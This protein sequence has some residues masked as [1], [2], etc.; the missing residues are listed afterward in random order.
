MKNPEK[1][2]P[3]SARHI[4]VDATKDVIVAGGGIAGVSA[5]LAAARQGVSVALLEKQFGLGGLATLG[6]VVKYLPLC[7]GYGKQVMGGIAEE[8]LHRSVCELREAL[9]SAGFQPVPDCWK[10]DTTPEDRERRRYMATFN[11][12]AFQMQL[13]DVLEEAG[14]ELFYDTR[15]CSVVKNGDD[16]SHVIVENKSGRLALE[17]KAFVDASGDA[18]LCHL[19]GCAVEDFPHNVL[20]SWYYEVKNGQLCLAAFSN[21]YDKEHGANAPGPFYSGTNHRDI[22]RQVLDSRK[23]LREKLAL[24]QAEDP[25]LTIHAFALPS[26]PDFRV[27]RRLKNEFSL[28]ESHRHVWFEDCIGITGDWR[29]KG[30]IYPLPFRAIHADTC[31]NLF[32]A[33]RCISSDKTVIDVT[34]AIGTCAVTG[35]ASGAAAAQT[36][37]EPGV[38]SVEKLQKTL[39]KV[40]ALIDPD[41]LKP[42]PKARA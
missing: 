3:E 11:P 5:A 32:V 36:V 19:A 18:D 35:E 9:P 40:G 33:G 24:K 4:P 1:S 23:L 12:Y 21:P 38:F 20:A 14:V 10:G 6:H 22:T 34:R 30:P 28:G 27:T 31:P 26:I 39:K 29:R 16:L 2:I 13:E 15:V 17:A 8:L 41:L 7:D 42:H 37:R 25:S